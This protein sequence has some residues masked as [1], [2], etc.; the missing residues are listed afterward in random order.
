MFGADILSDAVFETKSEL[1]GN[2]KNIKEIRYSDFRLGALFLLTHGG[3]I[4][5]R[6]GL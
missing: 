1:T 6:P 4:S 5:V 2:L 3:L